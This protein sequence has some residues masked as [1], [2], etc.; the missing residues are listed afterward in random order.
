[1]IPILNVGPD[2]VTQKTADLPSMAAVNVTA[3]SGAEVPIATI[4][5][6]ITRSD[7]RNVSLSC[8]LNKILSAEP[9]AIPYK[10]VKLTTT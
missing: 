6:P 1:M 8:S 3:N 7:S 2:N 5:N 10:I 4:V 9:S